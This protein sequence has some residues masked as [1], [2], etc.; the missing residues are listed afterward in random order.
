MQ[1]ESHYGTNVA[2]LP[3]YNMQAPQYEMIIIKIDGSQRIVGSHEVKSVDMPRNKALAALVADKVKKQSAAISNQA[4][5]V[6][7]PS[8]KRKKGLLNILQNILGVG[9]GASRSAVKKR[10]Q[11]YENKTRSV[12]NRGGNRNR[13]YRRP[14]SA[15]SVNNRRRNNNG[16]T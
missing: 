10:P 15:G 2:V 11:H 14:S 12:G 1:M 3:I 6:P 8:I 5:L 13:R 4:V 7:A 16:N 9:A